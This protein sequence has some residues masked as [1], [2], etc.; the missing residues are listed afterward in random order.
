MERNIQVQIYG[1]QYNLKTDNSNDIEELARVVEDRM[2]E[3]ER[4]GSRL[5][6]VDLAILTA[7]QLAEELA[8]AHAHQPDAS[9]EG[10]ATELTARVDQ[11]VE[12]AE[13]TQE[14]HD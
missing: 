1:R 2:N 12:L 4:Q 9:T 11:L 14:N 7:L 6:V 5:Q 8:Q 3:I 13:R 10:L